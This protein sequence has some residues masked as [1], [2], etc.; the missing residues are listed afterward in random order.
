MDK[1]TPELGEKYASRT[2]IAKDKIHGT[3]LQWVI[4]YDD[5]DEAMTIQAAKRGGYLGEKEKFCSWQQVRE[6]LRTVFVDTFHVC[7]K[8][9]RLPQKE[10]TL[11]LYGELYGGEYKGIKSKITPIQRRIF[12]SPNLHW[13]CFS[14]EVEFQSQFGSLCWKELEQVARESKLPLVPVY[15]IKTWKELALDSLLVMHPIPVEVEGENLPPMEG[16]QCEGV[17]FEVV[18]P[19][20]TEDQLWTLRRK[21]PVMFKHK[22][23]RFEEIASGRTAEE[24]KEKKENSRE[25]RC[26]SKDST[27]SYLQSSGKL[28]DQVFSRGTTG[29]QKHGE[30]H[31]RCDSGCRERIYQR[32]RNRID[33][34]AEQ[35][36]EQEFRW[37]S[38]TPS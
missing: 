18:D 6:Q 11:R 24:V 20:L 9:F 34:E 36:F 30:T 17:V 31:P 7:S 10:M 14:A 22:N 33:G 32:F 12:Y 1:W 15:A 29:Y 8:L 26:F 35:K 2:L 3:N 19:K 16:N 28:H 27:L 13:R 5:K 37:C 21:R 25:K 23:P 38:E 4:S